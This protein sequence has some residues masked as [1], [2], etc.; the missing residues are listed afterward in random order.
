MTAHDSLCVFMELPILCRVHQVSI[1]ELPLIAVIG[2]RKL[3]FRLK[4]K[5]LKFLN[6]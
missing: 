3:Q 1:L 6:L 4:L 2:Q 5:V